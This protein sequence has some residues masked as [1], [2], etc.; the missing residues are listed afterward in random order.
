MVRLPRG[1]T[2]TIQDWPRFLPFLWWVLWFYAAWTT[3]VLIGGLW[4]RVVDHWP[5]SVAMIFGSY[6]AGSTPMGGGT[7]GFP[8][9]VLLQ[10]EA[11]AL[12]R[13]FSYCIQSIGMVSATFFILCAR[14]TL[15]VRLLLWTLLSATVTLPIVYA[16][17]TPLAP[18]PVVKLTF[19][20]IW[21]GFGMLTLIK[22]RALLREHGMPAMGPKLEAGLGLGT[23]VVGGIA[24]GLTGVGIDMVLYT[25][26]VLVYRVDLRIA[27]PT[28][29]I[30]MAY[31]S[32]V[33]AINAAAWGHLD[34]EVFY[35]W[36]AA[37]P[38]VLLGA[39]VG[40]LALFV[41][42]RGVTMVIVAV[43]CLVQ[44]VWTCVDVGVRAST[45]GGVIVA[46]LAMNA[47]FHFLHAWGRRLVPDVA[48][49]AAAM[50]SPSGP[51]A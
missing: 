28:S 10:G 17:L 1:A 38:F 29:V 31:T 46:V 43:L 14:R 44:L 15:A 50:V 20:V 42:R 34:L 26:L 23:G 35:N 13:S 27:V 3:I 18:D 51:T 2:I 7:I 16:V 12:G 48:G 30:A 4:P 9:L 37:A 32:V 49:P 47:A 40:V 6:V 25:V 11:P 21:G 24:A 33:G 5:I 8:V 36:L 41:L 22:L 45:V 39:P 19:A